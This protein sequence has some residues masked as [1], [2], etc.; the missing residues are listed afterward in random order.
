MPKAILSYTT[1]NIQFRQVETMWRQIV[2]GMIVVVSFS[3]GAHSGRTN[4]QGCH[5]D[6]KNGGYHCH[7][8][9]RSLPASSV[10][11]AS[12][13]PQASSVAEDFSRC[14]QHVQDLAAVYPAEVLANTQEM[15]RVRFV[16]DKGGQTVTC[17]TTHRKIVEEF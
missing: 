1:V 13:T 6:R 16:R 17:L 8:G 4:A 15:Y 7:S 2:L 12:S 10:P 3:A 9:T 5:N 11:R 14:A